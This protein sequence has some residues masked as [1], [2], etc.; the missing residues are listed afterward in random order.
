MNNTENFAAKMMDRVTNDQLVSPSEFLYTLFAN[1]PYTKDLI[2]YNRP[3]DKNIYYV[4]PLIS[5]I[6]TDN[7]LE[8][9]HGYGQYLMLSIITDYI[10]SVNILQEANRALACIPPELEVSKK[11]YEGRVLGKL[12]KLQEILFSFNPLPYL[13]NEHNTIL[14]SCMLRLSL[15]SISYISLLTGTM[16]LQIKNKVPTVYIESKILIDDRYVDGPKAAYYKHVIPES[17]ENCYIFNTLDESKFNL[18]LH[19]LK[20]QRILLAGLKNVL[21][22]RS[23]KIPTSRLEQYFLLTDTSPVSLMYRN[24][25]KEYLDILHAA[26]KEIITK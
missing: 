2:E 7:C 16:F 24:D 11:V 12:D 5:S 19:I 14:F 15:L 3:F 1:H 8:L 9:S 23:I 6:D 20:C 17:F 10:A 13:N 18:N 4:M 26:M 25:S 21:M 22:H